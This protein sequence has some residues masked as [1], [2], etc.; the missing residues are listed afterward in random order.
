[1]EPHRARRTDVIV[2]RLNLF[3][4]LFKEASSKL[5]AATFKPN[6]IDVAYGDTFYLMIFE[7]DLDDNVPWTDVCL[8][9]FTVGILENICA[10]I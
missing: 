10:A 9:L 2:A 4:S 1:M 8:S 3:G 5:D 7:T 6:A